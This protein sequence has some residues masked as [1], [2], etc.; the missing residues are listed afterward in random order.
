MMRVKR[1]LHPVGHGAF[2]T[3]QFLEYANGSD[4]NVF[5]VV[6]DCGVQVNLPLLNQEIDDVFANTDRKHV[7]FLFISH[8][9]KDH[10]SGIKY[11]IKKS[12]AD[13]QTTFILPLYKDYHL[14]LYERLTGRAVL[15]IFN[16]IG[17]TQSKRVFYVPLSAEESYT[18]DGGT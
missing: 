4:K 10:V 1:V 13:A 11:L 15:S 16:L 12:Y 3:E 9:D 5:N 6:Y 17:Q 8:L 7:D 18:D 2:F 14:A